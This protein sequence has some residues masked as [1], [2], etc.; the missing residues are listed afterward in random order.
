MDMELFSVAI[1]G[2]FL[3]ALMFAATACSGMG[4]SLEAYRI[5]RRQQSQQ[6]TQTKPLKCW[7][8]QCPEAANYGEK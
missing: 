7:F 2:L 1:K 4:V 6:T 8:V 3:A 5:D